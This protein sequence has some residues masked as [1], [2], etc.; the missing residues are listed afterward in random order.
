MELRRCSVCQHEKVITEFAIT[1][2]KNKGYRVS[3]CNECRSA[4]RREMARKVK[5]EAIEYK[6]GKC[7]D[8]NHVVHQAAFE[9]HHIDPSTKAEKSKTSKQRKEPTHFLQGVKRLTNEAK[10]EL[11][12]CVLLC[13]N[14]HRVRHFS[15]LID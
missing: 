3:Y 1:G 9:F 15:D 4:A 2:S 14:C 6:G 8:C 12:K 11:D 5:A 7:N 10:Y 13:A